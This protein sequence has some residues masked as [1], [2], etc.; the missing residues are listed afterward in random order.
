MRFW[1]I[2]QNPKKQR[3][4]MQERC[5]LNLGVGIQSTWL[6]LKACAGELKPLPEVAIFSNTQ[7]ELYAT[8]DHLEWLKR[9]GTVPILTPTKG[10]LSVDLVKG[11]YCKNGN[12]F[13][14]IP[15]FTLHPDGKVGRARRQCTKEYKTEVIERCIRRDVF[16]LEP[17]QPLPR[18]THLIQYFGI[19]YDERVRKGRIMER[20]CRPTFDHWI[21]G[22]PLNNPPK[23]RRGSLT[24]PYPGPF[25]EPRFPLI[26]RQITREDCKAELKK[27]VPHHVPRSSCKFCPFKTDEE[28]LEMSLNHPLDFAEA[29][30]IDAALRTPG[31]VANRAMDDPMFVHRTC[32]PLVQID[33]KKLVDDKTQQKVFGFQEECTGMC[34]V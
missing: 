15:A 30:S 18:Q 9:N 27:L 4:K 11:Q 6:Y 17:R 33:F 21:L 1:R 28:W 24:V 23:V 22:N 7:D 12:R 34:G 13:A 16:G 19:S 26:D 3:G 8:Y 20:V 10:K 29:C 25:V 2:V 32:Q 5:V 31:G 14:S